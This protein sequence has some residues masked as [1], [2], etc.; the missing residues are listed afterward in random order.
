MWQGPLSGQGEGEGVKG[1]WV[2]HD[3]VV[4]SVQQR[5]GRRQV[6]RA[7]VLVL[8]A[9]QHRPEARLVQRQLPN[10]LHH[11]CHMQM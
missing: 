7:E 3:G 8:K 9:D 4:V 10:H 1:G 11:K 2:G 5:G 6:G